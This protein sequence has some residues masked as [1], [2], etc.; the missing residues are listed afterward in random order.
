MGYT[1]SVDWPGETK[2]FN[3]ISESVRRTLNANK[4]SFLLACPSVSSLGPYSFIAKGC[5]W[6]VL[7]SVSS[8]VE[9]FVRI[10][11]MAQERVSY[12]RFVNFNVF[13]LLKLYAQNIWMD[14]VN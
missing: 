7:K 8:C 1:D 3:S 5:S 2:P 6:G 4:E 13:K 14:G 10:W 9:I 11:P 12:S